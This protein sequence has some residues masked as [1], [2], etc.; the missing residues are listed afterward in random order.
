MLN[1]ALRHNL[2]S[3]SCAGVSLRRQRGVALIEVLVS[4]LL[5]SFGL[6]GLIALEARAVN[7]SVDAEDR[8]RA[9][10][11]AGEIASSMRLAG[12]ITVS[13]AQL[14]IWQTA[15]ADP[16]KT[17]LANGAVT[18]TPT[19]G[20]A[21]SADILVTWKPPSDSATAATSTLTTRVILP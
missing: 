15:I 20:L 2:R 13:A 12:T 4:V 17:G 21:N 18:I 6:L 19:A 14:G 5:F 9:A 7:F 1:V 3:M 8:N 10:L 11:F 16:T